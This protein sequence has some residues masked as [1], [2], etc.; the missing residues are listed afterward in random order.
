MC[1]KKKL[2]NFLSINF[3]VWLSKVNRTETMVSG[4]L[5]RGVLDTID[6]HYG[7]HA[8]WAVLGQPV[9]TVYGSSGFGCEPAQ[10]DSGV[11]WYTD[12]SNGETWAPLS[13]IVNCNDGY[14]TLFA[15]RPVQVFHEVRAD[16]RSGPQKGVTGPQRG[17][18]RINKV[19]SV[20]DLNL[21]KSHAKLNRA[22]QMVAFHPA[23][24]VHCGVNGGGYTCSLTQYSSPV[25]LSLSLVP[26]KFLEEVRTFDLFTRDKPWCFNQVDINQVY[27]IRA[28]FLWLADK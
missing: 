26:A 16:I 9:V 20:F 10:L 19:L 15:S 18:A 3:R 14:G 17:L 12:V 11:E 23:E 22:G 5:L 4:E 27:L 25:V 24:H 21:N 28:C 1:N 2:D 8:P 6:K 13:V 7:K